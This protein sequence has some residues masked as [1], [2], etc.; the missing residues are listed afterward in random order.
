MKQR[1]HRRGEKESEGENGVRDRKKIK[2][3]KSKKKRR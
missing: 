3:A 1:K 2:R